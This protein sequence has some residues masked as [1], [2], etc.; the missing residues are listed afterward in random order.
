MLNHRLPYTSGP[1]WLGEHILRDKHVLAVSGT[2]GKTTTSSMLAKILDFSGLQPGFLI[3]GVAQDFGVSARLSESQYFV[4]EADEYDSAFFDKRSKFVHYHAD[5]VI[6]NNLEFDHA[7]IFDD[8]AAIQTQFHHLIRTV[9][10]AGDIVYPAEDKNILSVLEQG[11][12]STK[13]TFG[14]DET[15][16]WQYQL[17]ESDGS[18][19]RI[20]NRVSGEARSATVAWQHCGLHNVKNAL[21]AVVAAASVGVRIEQSCRALCEFEGV[22]RRM[23]VIHDHNGVKVYDDFAHHPTAIKTTLEGLRSRVGEEPIL[24]IIEPRSATMKMGVHKQTLADSVLA[25][26]V[27]LWYNN[28][29]ADW[30]MDELRS[31]RSTSMV[32]TSLDSLI[33]QALDFAAGKGHILIMSN[34]GF[35]GL[36]EK[37][38]K[39]L[40]LT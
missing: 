40:A 27:V 35:G 16:L 8:L 11:C 20:I 36:H 34:G 10:S 17:M 18:V 28:G 31:R 19:F 21:A 29:L 4:V 3:G 32:V 25:A 7:D 1:A 15:N 37:L 33:E 22:K 13:Q 30:S 6:I 9:P 23:E 39:A 26:D 5:T 2:H 14:L 24:A 12:W 38:V